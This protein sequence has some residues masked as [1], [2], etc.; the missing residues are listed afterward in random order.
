MW[1]KRVVTVATG[2]L[3]VLGAVMPGLAQQATPSAQPEKPAVEKAAPVKPA[4]KARRAAGT[5]KTASEDSLTLEV[6]QKD[7][8]TKEYVFVLDPKAKISKAGKAIVA[9]DLQPGDR[10]TVAFAE[11][12]GK[13][14]ARTVTIRAQTAK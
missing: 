4:A 7:K 10:A 6:A 13:L 12:D 8:T 9:K 14:V 11:T 2:V 3:V 1:L 5:V